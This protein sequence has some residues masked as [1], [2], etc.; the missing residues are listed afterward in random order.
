MLNLKF[1]YGYCIDFVKV[2]VPSLP[3]AKNQSHSC[4]LYQF[5][6]SLILPICV[7]RR[8]RVFHALQDRL[9]AGGIQLK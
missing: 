8:L 4:N 5:K 2:I 1:M 6:L 7:F 9:F 3:K